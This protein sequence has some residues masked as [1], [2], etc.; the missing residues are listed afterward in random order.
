MMQNKFVQFQYF[1]IVSIC[2]LF[3]VDVYALNPVDAFQKMEPYL[4]I[5]KVLEAEAA[6]KMEDF[7][8]GCSASQN[9]FS[10]T[11]SFDDTDIVKALSLAPLKNKSSAVYVF[12]SLSLPKPA[13][14]ALN[15]EA[16]QLGA[17]LV[18]RGLKDNSYQK[19]ALYLQDLIEKTGQGFV[20]HPELFK[21]YEIHQVP[22]VVLTADTLGTVPSFDVVSGHIPIKTALLEMAQKGELKAEAK[23][24]LSR[25][26]YAD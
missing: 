23:D 24:W 10:A 9:H 8:C 26:S 4:E 12:V 14:V 22:S 20:I 6:F 1:L 13:L 7:Q 15:Q 5:A 3:L 16:V 25:G 21:R 19:T 2:G 18:L 17:T 11:N